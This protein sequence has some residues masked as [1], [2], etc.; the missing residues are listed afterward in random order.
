M[1]KYQRSLKGS[2]SGTL[3]DLNDKQNWNSDDQLVMGK[4]PSPVFS[5]KLCIFN[6][7]PKIPS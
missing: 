3:S 4:S 7:L 2:C 1:S 5:S 6:V